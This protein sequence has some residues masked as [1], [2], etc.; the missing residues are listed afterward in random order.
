MKFKQK[1]TTIFQLLFLLFF[2]LPTIQ[3]QK[4]VD[5]IFTKSTTKIISLNNKN[6]SAK[7]AQLNQHIDLGEYGEYKLSL[8]QTYLFS[9][10]YLARRAKK[11]NVHMKL[12]LTFKGTIQGQPNTLVSLTT[13]E[14][15]LSG[16]IDTG[17]EV[18]YFEPYNN[19]NSNAKKNELIIYYQKDVIDQG[20]ACA[21]N[22][23]NLQ[24]KQITPTN[25]QTK[26]AATDCELEPVCN[27]LV[28]EM[29]LVADYEMYDRHRNNTLSYIK[30]VLQNVQSNYDDEFEKSI[31]FMVVA[32]Y[33][34]TQPSMDLWTSESY[35][36][37]LLNE[38]K[39]SDFTD[40]PYDLASLWVTRDI[41]YYNSNDG[42]TGLATL[43]GVC[44]SRYNLI[45]DGSNVATLRTTLAHEI[46]HNFNATHDAQGSDIMAASTTSG[47]NTWSEKSEREINDF[48]PKATCLCASGY[49]AADMA[50]ES[51]GSYGLNGNTLT[52]S[53]VVVKNFGTIPTGTNVTT[54]WY[55]STDI[56]I[57]T[58]DYHIATQ[59]SGS[60]PPTG[61]SLHNFDVDLNTTNIPSG[62]YYL[63]VI[64]DYDNLVTTEYSEENNIRSLS[65]SADIT[66]QT[67][68]VGSAGNGDVNVDGMFNI[69]DAYI[70]S[71]YSVGL[72]VSG[73]CENLASGEL[74]LARADMDCD[75]NFNIQDAY[76]IARCVVGL[77]SDYCPD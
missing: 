40:V 71:Q 76:H 49:V 64:T 46:G 31:T 72:R 33:I 8:E 42:V 52:I 20:H 39:E 51:C 66:I 65:S 17:E 28:V 32:D 77:P 18:I 57:T 25:Q 37:G 62:N 61:F 23:T 74:C 6:L 43:G 44:N 29:V 48:L 55:L 19:F 68:S 15:F 5:Q 45:E 36:P 75:G 7:S 47:S 9:D 63:G 26:S 35:A 12:P 11:N 16:F 58:S 60:Y 67:C 59:T 41:W 4:T 56:T 24:A 30:S 34:A 69:L 3:A 50:I 70:I 27:E 73:D 54:R 38:F 22:H 10:D 13:S 21:A 1:T 2:C 14:D 53:D